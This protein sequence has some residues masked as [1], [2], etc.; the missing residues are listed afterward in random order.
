MIAQ[1]VFIQI[2]GGVS[3]FSNLYGEKNE[4]TEYIY[5]FDQRKFGKNVKIKYL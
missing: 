2:G 1:T 3:V 5:I 4:I